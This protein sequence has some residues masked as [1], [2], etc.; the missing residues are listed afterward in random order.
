MNKIGEFHFDTESYQM[1]FRG[2]VTIPMIGNYLI[3]AASIHAANRGFGYS[4][5]TEKHTAWVLSRLAIEITDYPKSSESITVYTWVDE[6][7]RLFTSRCF[8][9]ANGEGKTFGFARSIWAAIDMET[10]RPTLLDVEGLSAYISDR[11]CPI[12]KPGKIVPVEA[13]TEAVPYKVKYSDLDINGHLNSIKYMEHLLDLFDIG[14][15]REK[16]ISR[17]EIAYQ[18]EGKYGMMLG[19]HLAEA[20]P[21]KYDMAICHDEKAIC[22]AAVTWK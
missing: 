13:K 9:L 21:G 15:F 11:P 2:R 10:R 20:A 14:M 8:E 17:F 19:L 16:E 18:A 7:G 3:H 5:M 22:R 12:E 6:V 1:D 4:D